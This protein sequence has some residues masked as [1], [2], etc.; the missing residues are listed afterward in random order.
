MLQEDQFLPG[1][2]LQ[3]LQYQAQLRPH[4][5]ARQQHDEMISTLLELLELDHHRDEMV[6]SFTGQSRLS[7]GEQ[8]RA[9]LAIQL[10]NNQQVLFLDESMSGLDTSLSDRLVRVWREHNP[11]EERVPRR[12]TRAL[13]A[14]HTRLPPAKPF[15]VVP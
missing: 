11:V 7:G 15:A 12:G 2:T 6:R 13:P 14:L 9:S 10:R 1:L 8:R 5:S 4:A 3:T